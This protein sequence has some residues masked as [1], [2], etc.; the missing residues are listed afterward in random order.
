M[1]NNKVKIV[2]NLTSHILRA[3]EENEKIEK[4]R[5]KN[6]DKSK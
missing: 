1:K 2:G 6:L 4:N 5:K 3:M